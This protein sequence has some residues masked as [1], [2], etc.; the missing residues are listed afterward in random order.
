[1]HPI[2]QAE[3]YWLFVPTDWKVRDLEAHLDLL[4]A[5][6]RAV[7]ER[8]R[9]DRKKIEFLLGRV[10]LKRLLA[11]RLGCEVAEVRFVK[12]DY[13]KLFLNREA[14]PI[15]FNLTHSGQL[16]ACAFA[17]LLI[18][19]DVEEA[20][21]DYLSVMPTV[22][23]PDEQDY[24]RQATT[25]ELQIKAFCRIWTR[26]EAYVKAVGKGLSISPDSFAVPIFDTYGGN[27]P[28][29]VE[30]TGVHRWA[31]YTCQPHDDYVLSLA[32]A[33]DHVEAAV[34]DAEVYPMLREL[35]PYEL[36]HFGNTNAKAR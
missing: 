15:Q 36:L 24:V 13:G 18:G 34:E 16:I 12:N 9:V 29:M 4:D 33:A 28:D 3:V 23:T 22:F 1:M 26:K 11:E 17:P 25:S 30:E 7:Y 35:D 10:L 21:K 32:V 6:E 14:Q 19:V 27:A 5:E 2:Q 8:Y 31:Y 20:Q